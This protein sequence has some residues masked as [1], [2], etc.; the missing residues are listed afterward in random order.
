MTTLF[1]HITQ[2]EH[3]PVRCGYN[4]SFV[5]KQIDRVSGK[6]REDA[7]APQAYSVQSTSTLVPLVTTFQPNHPKLPAI[8]TYDLLTTAAHFSMPKIIIS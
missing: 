5:R 2:L 3:H 6:T 4:T 8:T 7:L 1:K